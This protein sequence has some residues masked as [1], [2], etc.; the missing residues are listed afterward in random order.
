MNG[1]TEHS[2]FSSP[3]KRSPFFNVS[4]PNVH[5]SVSF[6][7]ECDSIATSFDA[8]KLIQ[9]NKKIINKIFVFLPY[10]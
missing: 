9:R 10:N 8:K 6:S 1:G 2:Q 7:L 5:V 4:S 3:F